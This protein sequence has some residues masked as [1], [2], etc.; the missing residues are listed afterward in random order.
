MR[1]PEPRPDA[2]A[3][4]AVFVGGRLKPRGRPFLPGGDGRQYAYVGAPV[5]PGRPPVAV[6]AEE[7]VAA[8]SLVDALRSLAPP[9]EPRARRSETRWEVLYLHRGFSTGLKHAPDERRA[10]ARAAEST[11]ARQHDGTKTPRCCTEPQACSSSCCGRDGARQRRTGRGAARVGVASASLNYIPIYGII[12]YPYFSFVLFCSTTAVG[13]LSAPTGPGRRRRTSAGRRAADCSAG[14]QVRHSVRTA[15]TTRRSSSGLTCPP[16]S[17]ARPR[18]SLASRLLGWC[19]CTR[20]RA[21][22]AFADSHAPDSVA[23]GG[24]PH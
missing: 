13:A 1:Q 15:S 8:R 16:S 10:A 11:T 4:L 21:G 2:T 23:C 5:A 3:R 17:A 14:A 20:Q 24:L 12:I 18:H 19:A 22:R 7:S 9:V 6:Q